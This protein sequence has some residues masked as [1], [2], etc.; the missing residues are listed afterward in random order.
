MYV[1]LLELKS[2]VEDYPLAVQRVKKLATNATFK[3]IYCL[4]KAVARNILQC[5]F[6]FH[7]SMA[8]LESSADTNYFT[9][10]KAT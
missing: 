3:Y 4:M 5:F 7:C 8:V 1:K 2:S 9:F 6:S 10:G